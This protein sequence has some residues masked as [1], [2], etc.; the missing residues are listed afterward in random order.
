M[1]LNVLRSKSRY[2]Y[3]EGMNV[4]VNKWM[5]CQVNYFLNNFMFIVIIIAL[6]I[7]IKRIW[8]ELFTASTFTVPALKYN[9]IEQNGCISFFLCISNLEVYNTANKYFG[10]VFI[11]KR[12]LLRTL[13]QI[14]YFRF[15]FFI[16]LVVS[17]KPKIR[18]TYVMR[19]R[20]ME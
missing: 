11:S 18:S 6:V 20:K 13:G 17:I 5:I 15:F 10:L 2:G 8:N 14:N 3:V 4:F 16:Q 9:P 7:N 12:Q 1:K 19:L